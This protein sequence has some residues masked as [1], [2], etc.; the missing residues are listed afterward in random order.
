MDE[1]SGDTGFAVEPD[2]APRALKP[3]GGTC[4][5]SCQCQLGLECLPDAK[6][7]KTCQKISIVPAPAQTPCAF[8]CQCPY[9][10]SCSFSGKKYGVCRAEKVQCTHAC[11]CGIHGQ[12][13]NGTCQ[14]V[15]GPFPQC[16]CNDNCPFSATC[17]YG[18]CAGS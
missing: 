15:P 17:S 12:C 1:A 6:G 14:S 3:V 5:T 13:V 10:Q 18:A 9:G 7:N 8:S 2:L 4:N 16:A 11:D